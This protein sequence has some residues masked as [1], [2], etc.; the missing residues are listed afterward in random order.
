MGWFVFVTDRPDACPKPQS[1]APA[2]FR[3]GAGVERDS[4][5]FVFVRSKTKTKTILEPR[6]TWRKN[7]T[8]FEARAS[9]AFVGTHCRA[10]Y[11]GRQELIFLFD[12]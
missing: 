2:A 9:D 11:W 6:R 5:I 3:L 4:V 7:I 1:I 8:L 10:V 12:R